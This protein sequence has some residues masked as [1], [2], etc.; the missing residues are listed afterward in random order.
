MVPTSDLV[1]GGKR[2]WTVRIVDVGCAVGERMDVLVKTRI[3]RVSCEARAAPTMMSISG[4][5]ERERV[6]YSYC[7]FS[8]LLVL[9][10]IPSYLR[11]R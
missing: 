4:V 10:C 8:S 9:R 2:V 1:R 11:L 5:S 3:W 6:W 7:R